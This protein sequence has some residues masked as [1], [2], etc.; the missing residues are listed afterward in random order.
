MA[1][2]E[3]LLTAFVCLIFGAIQKV[4]RQQRVGR[5][6]EICHFCPRLVHKN[7]LKGRWVVQKERDYVQVVFE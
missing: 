3:N 2:N 1:P 5:W 4:R 7:V 6:S